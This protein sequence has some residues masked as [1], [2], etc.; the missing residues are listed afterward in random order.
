[1]AATAQELKSEIEDRRRG[2]DEDLNALSDKV[3]PTKAARRRAEAA[4]DKLGSAKDAV[5][6]TASNA[7]GS[8]T[9]GA[10]DVASS[11]G[12]VPGHITATTRGNP[13]AAGLVAFGLGM[14]VSALIPAS[15]PERRAAAAVDP[16]LDSLARAA[17]DHGR[18]V[19]SELREPA[20]AAIQDI[21]DDATQRAS[22]VQE[23]ASGHDATTEA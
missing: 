9:G 23:T 2:I 8:V 6:G 17:A 18:E 10:S 13:L 12:A 22:A 4:R 16:H 21:T 20:K 15:E 1:M 3:N 14:V 11:A 5:M 19:A 7:A